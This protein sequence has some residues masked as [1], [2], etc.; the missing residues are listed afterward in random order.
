MTEAELAELLAKP[1]TREELWT[2]MH[3]MRALVIAGLGAS[4]SG[5][6]EDRLTAWRHFDAVKAEFDK[7][8][9][10]LVGWNPDDPYEG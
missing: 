1:V 3:K 2:A 4:I 5:E 7:F 8:T 10:D 6:T 9:D